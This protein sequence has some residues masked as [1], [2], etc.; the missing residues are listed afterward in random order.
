[1]P[2]ID[3][4][5]EELH[6]Y[7]G[8]NPKPSD[9]DEFWDDGL[10][11]M[12]ALDPKVEFVQAE[13][14]AKGADCFH[15]WFTGTGGS[16]VHAKLLR[17]AEILGKAPAVL[18][19]HGYSMNSGDWN[20]K[21]NYVS[22]GFV[23]A[24]LD[25]RGQGGLSDDTVAVRGTTLRGHII[26]GLND[27]P[28]RLYYRNVFLD[29]A[30]LARIVMELPQVD[31]NRVVATGGSQG[32]GL[33]LA[34]AALEP[35][36]KKAAPWFPFLCDYLRVWEMD[37]DVAA[38]EELRQFFRHH[39]PR[40]ERKDHFFERLGYIDVQHLAPR[41][42]AEVLMCTGLMDAICPPSTQFAA[43]NKITSKKEVV[44]YPDFGHE[45]LPGFGD[46]VFEFLTE[47]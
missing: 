13:F 34:C 6:Q 29:T 24:A 17:P 5:L 21:L 19:F 28:E 37:Q 43:F 45:G 26:R 12:N 10:A 4:P 7:A 14:S 47:I 38:Y 33:T 2:L 30:L 16:R 35:R 18:Q 25:C 42:K 41:I 23:V 1:M 20:E 3:L 22:Q 27:R 36:I 44:I 39:D 8:R 9:F 31:E 40:H 46:K 11:E 32:G 15:L